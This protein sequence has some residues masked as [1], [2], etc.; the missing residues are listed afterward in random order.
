MISNVEAFERH[1]TEQ[2][3]KKC[4][5]IGGKKCPGDQCPMWWKT[6]WTLV[7]GDGPQTKLL[8]GCSA[9]LSHLY[10]QEII[11]AVDRLDGSVASSE[12]RQEGAL[13]EF[14][15]KVSSGLVTLGQAIQKLPQLKEEENGIPVRQKRIRRGS[16][17]EEGS[18][19]DS[20]PEA[21]NPSPLSG[22][23]N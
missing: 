9:Q 6:V 22:G 17:E 1:L 23:G 12:S 10:M 5:L 19:S 8:E 4:P 2:K 7:K 20:S 21:S 15:T 14:A 11:R 16:G 18:E 13:D 3:G